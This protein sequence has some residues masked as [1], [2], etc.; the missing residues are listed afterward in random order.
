MGKV[1][2]GDIGTQ[3]KIDMQ[4]ALTGYSVVILKVKKPN[5][6]LVQWYPTVVPN[7]EGIE[8]V[9]GYITL[10][11]DL[12]AR[13]VYKIQPYIE[14][15]SWKGKGTPVYLEVFGEYT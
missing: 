13:G 9:L 14:F 8:S 1:Y 7:A 11:G 15:A 5:G 12:N 10:S 2:V 3:I 6:S 4:E